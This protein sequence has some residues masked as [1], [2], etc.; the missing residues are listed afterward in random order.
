MLWT[1]FS[2]YLFKYRLRVDGL[3]HRLPSNF[4]PKIIVDAYGTTRYRTSMADAKS[5]PQ[6]RKVVQYV[7]F[8]DGMDSDGHGTHV[9][10]IAAGKVGLA[11][12]RYSHLPDT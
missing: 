11:G 12:T 3:Q 7:D 2:F 10:G 9:A 6:Q 1:R 8:A 4:D 5:Y